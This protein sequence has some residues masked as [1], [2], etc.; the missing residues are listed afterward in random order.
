MKLFKN[1]LDYFNLNNKANYGFVTLPSP[2]P[3]PKPKPVQKKRE[4]KPF[5][6]YRLIDE[7]DEAVDYQCL[8]C[9]ETFSLGFNPTTL[10]FC[11]TCGIEFE[12][13]FN[14]KNPRYNQYTLKYPYRP[15][16]FVN[17]FIRTYHR[18]DIIKKNS[19]KNMFSRGWDHDDIVPITEERLNYTKDKDNYYKWEEVS[20]DGIYPFL[21]HKSAK[22]TLKDQR[23]RMK[24]YEKTNK[25]IQ[26]WAGPLGK[27]KLIK[28]IIGQDEPYPVGY[29]LITC[30]GIMS[31]T[32]A[33]SG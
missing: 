4:K 15:Q 6:F 12:G 33:C 2:P 10:K 23:Q 11:P 3:E 9:K 1:L 18:K 26:L 27:E 31:S 19:D 17:T 32:T 20:Q 13:Q 14:K 21:A 25:I 5:P 16:P 28:E 24:Y 30:S 29:G 8:A 22:I 7:W